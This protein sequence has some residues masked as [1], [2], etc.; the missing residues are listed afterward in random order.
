MDDNYETLVD[1]AY[2]LHIS[3]DFIKAK[4]AYE[5]LLEVNPDDLNVLNL[6]GQLNFS[7]KNYD[8]A[9]SI[10]K[11]IYEKTQLDDIRLNIIKVYL[12][13]NDFQNAIDTINS[14]QNKDIIVLRFLAQSYIS[15]QNFEKAIKTYL[16]ILK[17][18][19]HD[20]TD[21]FN[22]SVAY[23]KNNDADNALKYALDV[24]SKNNN[25]VNVCLQIASVYRYI[26][27][28]EKELDYL[29][30]A[31]QIQPSVDIFYNIGVLYRLLGNDEEALEYF[32]AI[33]EVQPDNK[34]AYLNIARIYQTH[35]KNIS[36][37]IYSGLADKYP[38]DAMILM[39]LYIMYRE[40]YRHDLAYETALR[41]I[42]AEPEEEY[43][44]SSAGDALYE[45]GR[46]E[47]AIHMFEK[48]KQYATNPEYCDITIAN[49]Y[50]EMNKNDKAIQIFKTKYPHLMKEN[51]TY[52][53]IQLREKNLD[54]VR[55]ALYKH[56]SKVN[57]EEF[58]EKRAVKFFY[59]LN[60]DKKYGINEDTFRKVKTGKTGEDID[61]A[62]YYLKNDLY[63]HNPDNKKIFLYS[64]HGAGDIIMFSRYIHILAK[65]TKN[66]TI[67]LPNSMLRLMKYNFPEY[68]I[69]SNEKIIN[70]DSYDYSTNFFSLLCSLNETTLKDIPYSK[71]YLSVDKSITKEKSMFDFMQTDKK[72]IGI[73][74]NGNPV[75][76]PQRS[77]KFKYL[78][79]LFEIPNSQIY[80]F[81]ISNFDY[82]VEQEKGDLAM[83]D[84]AP[85]IKDY[86]DTAGFLENIDVLVTI[87][88][89]IANLAGAMGIKTYLLLPYAS[90]WRWFYDTDKT[91]WYD[92][93][94]IFKQK[95]P[96]D[97]QDVIERVK[98]ELQV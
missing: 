90:E 18:K 60:I 27:D 81:Q 72:K 75:V 88:T 66:I 49:M 65:H 79:S 31:A 57:T 29:L 55:Y 12:L 94:K 53:F 26:D 68:E 63:S 47:E 13:Q 80:S 24:F 86:A 56:V 59:K 14:I 28:K 89:S 9:L 70:Q 42:K 3:G 98:Y 17:F 32:K 83:I 16:D 58:I 48:A 6:Y 43:A 21:L 11:K 62:I 10:F 35:D 4:E 8:I 95:I 15:I 45:L 7:L 22:L 74:W 69:L 34:S 52:A 92:S 5:N 54:E 76:M 97:W 96:Y 41:V 1:E 73:F 19:E 2:N 37:N 77:I 40:M 50:S 36:I 91:P 46:Y 78:K 23:L 33:V 84:L 20:T 87:D 82:S 64:S 30:K 61:R 39:Q 71:K 51:T 67:Q 38:D 85:F 44:Y 25:D 93:I